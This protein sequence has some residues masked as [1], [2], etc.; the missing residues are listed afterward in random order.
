MRV[1]GGVAHQ[2]DEVVGRDLGSDADDEGQLGQPAGDL[3]VLAMLQAFER[4]LQTPS[5]VMEIGE[6]AGVHSRSVDCGTPP[7]IPFL[8]RR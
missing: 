5:G 1:L 6:G 8:A 3:G 7:P 4:L 2:G